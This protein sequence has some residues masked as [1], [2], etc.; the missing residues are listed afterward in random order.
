MVTA[1]NAGAMV[2]IFLSSRLGQTILVVV[3]SI[4]MI[5]LML[6]IARPI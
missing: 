1:R 5:L 6:V 2:V 4:V 3:V